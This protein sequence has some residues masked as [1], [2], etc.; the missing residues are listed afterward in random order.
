[1]TEKSLLFETTG[2]VGDGVPVTDDQWFQLFRSF[3][4][5]ANAGGVAPDV[6][7]ELAV[8]GTAT[9]VSVD[10]GQAFV[11][12]IPY[13]NTA[14]VTVAI[15]TPGAS[16][17]IDR[18]VLRASWAA[19]TVRITRI[20]GTEGAGVPAMTQT[21]GTTWD[22]PLANVSITTGAVITV[23]DAREWVGGVGDLSINSS[24]LA[25]LSVI[26]GKIA[27]DAVG[28]GAIAADAVGAAQI[29]DY[30][31][32]PRAHISG[33]N[34]IVVDPQNGN[35]RGADATDLQTARTIASQVASGDNSV[36]VGGS[37]NVASSQ[38][39]V[40]VGGVLNSAS[41]N[42]AVVLGGS[43]NAASAINS[44]IPGGSQARAD[45]YGQEAFAAGGFSET[46]STAQR[47]TFVLR[48]STTNATP[49]EL[50]L[51]GVDDRLTIL[52]QYTYAFR[53]LV[54]ARRTDADNE[55]AAYEFVGC[56]DNNGGTTALV[57]SVTKTVIAED[58]AAWDVN[59]TADN[60]NDALI[61]TVTG[62]AAKTIRWVATVWT[63]EVAG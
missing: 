17:R 55:C 59:V 15:A 2:A 30:A 46:V 25:A 14:A 23:T 37:S 7:N 34:G 60:T 11:Y 38:Y 10:T 58:S 16:T 33:V 9:P 49:A 4:P 41:A 56:I 18:I 27:A 21:A 8:T 43:S 32:D 50:F 19:Q 63:T 24:K 1:M 44:A 6:L 3:C 5:V 22:I 45:K 42:S 40:V 52:D 20:A 47:S 48:I 53:A 39:A 26:A 36:I 61:I 51:D 28:A 12:G 57:G 62:E 29:A 35:A 54:V 31:V 13:Y